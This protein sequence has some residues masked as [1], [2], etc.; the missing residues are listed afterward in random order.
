[1]LP[2]APVWSHLRKALAAAMFAAFAAAPAAEASSRWG[3]DYLPNVT[4]VTQEGKSVR[5]YDDVLA[6][7][8]VV[9]SFIYATCR[10]ICPLITARLAQVYESLGEAAGREIHFVSIS[11][12]PLND[13]PAKLKQHADAFRSDQKWLFLTGTKVNIDLVRHKLGERS[14]ALSE[15][16]ANVMLYNDHT[17]AWSRDS[18]FADAGALAFAIRSMNPDWRDTSA[19]SAA[20]GGGRV[21]ASKSKEWPG[22][23]LFVKAC[24]SCHTIGQGDRVGPDLHGVTARRERTWL[25]EFIQHPSRLHANQDPTALALAA[26]YPKIR[27][28]NLQVSPSDVND[29]LA[30]I[31]ARTYKATMRQQDKAGG[32]HKH[33]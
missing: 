5:F 18:A 26:A 15:H 3:K 20:V 12:D 28:P 8:I 10:D 29:L 11:I 22:Q 17:G 33:H 31:D 16:A 9:I 27:M 25:S 6:G 30:Y 13:T 7:K 2:F 32:R 14:R 21:E 1:M 4:L 23:S 19:T 24:A